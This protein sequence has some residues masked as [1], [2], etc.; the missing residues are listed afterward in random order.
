MNS[1]P[2]LSSV[3]LPLIAL[4]ICLSACGG[5]GSDKTKF[6]PSAASYEERLFAY[7]DGSVELRVRGAAVSQ[8]FFEGAS[9]RPMLGRSFT[10]DDFN[11]AGQA[12]VMICKG[13]WVRHFKS[14]PSIIGKPVVIDGVNRVV[15]G[16]LPDSINVPTGAEIW[17]PKS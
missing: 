3:V 15:V 8:S 13:F 1:K 12:V 6:E 4:M 2:R 7:S 10:K 11:Q 9:E 16:I 17:I 5:P 14:D